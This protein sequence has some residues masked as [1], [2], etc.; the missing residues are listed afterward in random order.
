MM[1]RF[2]LAA[3]AVLMSGAAM[4]QSGTIPGTTTNPS[5]SVVT[6]PGGVPLSTGVPTAASPGVPVGSVAQPRDIPG[7]ANNATTPGNPEAGNA[8]S[9]NAGSG[10]A[11]GGGDNSS[12]R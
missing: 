10:G 9:G 3:A 6:T 1:T 4:A 11:G 5:G 2:A 7:A 12:A 8:N